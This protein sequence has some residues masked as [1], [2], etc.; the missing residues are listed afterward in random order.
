MSQVNNPE[1]VLPARADLGG[2]APNLCLAVSK[3]FLKNGALKRFG[4]RKAEV[5]RFDSMENY[6]ADR[7]EQISEY[8]TLF[9]P[10]VSF[11]G[12]TVLEVGCNRGYLL[13]SFL[14]HET[15]TAVGADINPEALAVARENYGDRIKFVQTTATGIPLPDASVD[16]IY[17]IDTVEHLSRIREMFTDC[18]RVLKPGGTMLV[19]FQGWYGPYGSHLEDI[20]PFPWPNVVFSMDTLLKV[21]A[22][23]YD[24]PDYD[25]ACYFVD[26]KTGER[27]PNPYLDRAQWDE[28]LNHLT[29]RQFKR[30]IR[31][32]PF[33]VV[34]FEN[35]GFGGRTYKVGQYLSHLSKVPVFN[36]FF[37][38]ATFAVLKKPAT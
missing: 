32:L 16:V 3:L 1:A 7:T 19:H 18:L 27:K 34:H 13:N 25:V 22:H 11:G 29:I 12:K 14:Q 9:R 20:I 38:K 24:S 36:E 31:E 35:I 23:L 37:T 33:E 8:Q 4:F 15:F 30:L 6:V 26:E 2:L 5:T 17:T 28:F 10:F 21:A